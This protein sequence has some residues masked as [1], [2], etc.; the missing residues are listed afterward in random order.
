MILFPE[1]KIAFVFPARTGS[2][3]AVNFL[4]FSKLKYIK[5]PDRHIF[6]DD[7]ILVY[8]ELKNFR[9]YA[10]LRHPAEVLASALIS[11]DC[12]HQ[13]V[14][15]LFKI[16]EKNITDSYFDFME[17]YVLKNKLTSSQ[18]MPQHRYFNYP[19]VTVMNY[20][21]YESELRLAT[22]DLDLSNVTIGKFNTNDYSKLN[23]DKN[24]FVNW[25]LPFVQKQYPEYWGFWQRACVLGAV[26][27]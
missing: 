10:M 21:N 8:P 4:T 17:V 19:N 15:N 11:F 3:T 16:A 12:A 23:I 18:Y 1:Q 22:K 27:P 13:A 24:T 14:K 20:R 9:I 5:H 7:A 2:T 25:L 6:T 26:R